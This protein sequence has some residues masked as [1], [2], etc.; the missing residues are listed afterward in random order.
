MPFF[1]KI[2]VLALFDTSALPVDDLFAFPSNFIGRAF[3]AAAHESIAED[4]AS[5]RFQRFQV[6]TSFF[7]IIVIIV[8]ILNII[9]I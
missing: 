6:R 3:S 5:S 4:A 8:I 9:M 7:L 2:P 1:S